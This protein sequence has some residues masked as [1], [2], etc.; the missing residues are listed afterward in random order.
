[1]RLRRRSPSVSYTHLDVYKRQAYDQSLADAAFA[2][3][4]LLKVVDGRISAQLPSQPQP[5]A[6]A[7]RAEKFYYSIWGPD[8]ILI[9]GNPQ[10]PAASA[11][12][13]NLTYADAWLGSHRIR[14][15]TYRVAT[16]AGVATV[17]V[18]ETTSR[19]EAARH[20][21]LTSTW[22]MD[23]ILVDSTLLLVWIGVRYG[24]KPLLAVRGQIESR[25]PRELRPLETTE[26]PA[27]VRPLVDA[28]NGLFEVLREAARA[29]RQF[30]A[31][32][33]HQLRT[34][35]AGL[36][37]HLELLTQDPAAAELES[38]LAVLRDGMSR[39][40]HSANQLLALARA[41]LLYTSFLQATPTM[42]R[43]LGSLSLRTSSGQ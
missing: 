30:V 37:G 10:L 26:V 39:V 3:A 28:L 7:Y 27:E 23:F 43:I 21:I 8:H 29:Q 42:Q 20:F 25:S 36:V 13:G 33:A 9:T 35:I 14:V 5:L 41:C 22:L 31:D 34:P 11:G 1:M 16:A 24:L 40:A 4:A 6:H 15:V 17:N 19:R 18:A 2:Q 32:A 12:E 38:R